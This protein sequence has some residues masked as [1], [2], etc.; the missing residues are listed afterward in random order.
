MVLF[1]YSMHVRKWVCSSILLNNYLINYS[2]T[3]LL[4]VTKKEQVSSP[5]PFFMYYF[6]INFFI[7]VNIS[8][9]IASP[10]TKRTTKPNVF[11]QIPCNVLQG[12]HLWPNIATEN[13]ASIIF[14]FLTIKL[15]YIDPSR[16]NT[17][18]NVLHRIFQSNPI[19]Q[20]V[21]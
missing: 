13:F 2:V 6:R 19:L 18:T 8:L 17:T 3:Q 4:S 16:P 11:V 20:L 1:K 14:P 21:I 15:S 10:F 12:T 5:A 7:C 9:A